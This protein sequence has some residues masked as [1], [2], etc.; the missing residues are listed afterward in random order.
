MLKY[1]NSQKTERGFDQIPSLLEKQLKDTFECKKCHN[2]INF[3]FFINTELISVNAVFDKNNDLWRIETP[4]LGLLK[5]KDIK[6]LKC[7]AKF[8]ISEIKND[9]NN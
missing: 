3:Q 7:G 8:D 2:K 1:N 9:N 6:C 5:I 4:N